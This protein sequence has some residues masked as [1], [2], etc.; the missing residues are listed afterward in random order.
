MKD[1]DLNISTSTQL[2]KAR[3]YNLQF[4]KSFDKNIDL[5]SDTWFNVDKWLNQNEYVND[6]KT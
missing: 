4:A 2:Q 1:N 5:G 6:N 3:F